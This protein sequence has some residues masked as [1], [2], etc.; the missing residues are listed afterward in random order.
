MLVLFRSL[1]LVE[2]EATIAKLEE[3]DFSRLLY[4]GSMEAA[5]LNFLSRELGTLLDSLLLLL[6][7]LFQIL[8]HHTKMFVEFQ[9]LKCQKRLIALTSIL[10]NLHLLLHW[11]H[12]EIQRHFSTR[13]YRLEK[14][15]KNFCIQSFGRFFV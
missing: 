11:S 4:W 5:R 1:L 14:L 9:V 7:E 15:L 3:E 12:S 6:L 2:L 10:I 13:G 8:S